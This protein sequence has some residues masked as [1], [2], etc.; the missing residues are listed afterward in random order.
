MQI[1]T[2]E[3][4]RYFERY[5]AHLQYVVVAHTPYSC[6]SANERQ[7]AELSQQAQAG[8]RH[9]LNCFAK[10]LY[11]GSTNKSV[12]KPQLYRPLSLTTMEGARQTAN[13]H[14]TIHY[15]IFLGNIPTQYIAGDIE[16]L[17]RHAWHAKAG[18]SDDVKLYAITEQNCR[19]WIG[20]TL[21]ETGISRANITGTY[22]TWDV[23]NSYI[24]HQ[25][26]VD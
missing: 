1:T 18:M 17:F 4:Q 20:Y 26:L 12:R 16:A 15:N 9:A 13:R 25:A 8:C 5:S 6:Y 7:I 2:T 10:S 11:K 21:K 14:L 23:A 19:Q 24:P 22:T 3:I